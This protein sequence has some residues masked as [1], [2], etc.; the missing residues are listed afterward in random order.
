MEIL[1][2]ICEKC[3]SEPCVGNDGEWDTLYEKITDRKFQSIVDKKCKDPIPSTW[4]KLAETENLA[5]Y[6]EG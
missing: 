3:C 2:F 5:L 4:V 1:P 6:Q